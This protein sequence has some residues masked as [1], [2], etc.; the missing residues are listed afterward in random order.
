MSLAHRLFQTLFSLLCLGLLLTPT[1][2][3]ASASQAALDTMTISNLALINA[4]TDQPIAGYE[5]LKGNVALDLTKL[6]T[7][8]LSIVAT[9]KPAKIGS[10]Q[11]TLDGR[12]IQTENNAPYS[13]KGDAPKKAG[14]NYL[15]WTPTAGSHTLIVTPLVRQMEKGT[16]ARR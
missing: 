10:V 8:R 9:T 4:D 14:R 1:P 7:S 15:P 16:P 5:A 11:F 12:V 3:T 2:L 6:G 13:I